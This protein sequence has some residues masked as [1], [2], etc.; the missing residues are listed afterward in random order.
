MRHKQ[1]HNSG[2]RHD[3]RSL[4]C[5]PFSVSFLCIGQ[6][7]EAQKTEISTHANTILAYLGE[8]LHLNGDDQHVLHWCIE[9]LPSGRDES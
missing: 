3:A 5:L 8:R 7:T 6:W 4:F 1:T 2:C 9:D